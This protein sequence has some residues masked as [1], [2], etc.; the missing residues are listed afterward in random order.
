MTNKE[1]ITDQPTHLATQRQAANGV[2]ASWLAVRSG[3]R[4]LL[5]PLA[6]AGEI[7]SMA[8]IAPVPHTLAWFVG[9]VNLRGGLYGV[10]DLAGFMGD[11]PAHPR[12]AQPT[13]VTFNPDLKLNCAL[14][15]D[16]LA[17][18]R[19]QDSFV[20]REVALAD[21]PVYFGSLLTD[22]EGGQWQ[23]INLHL[24]SQCPEFLRISV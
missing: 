14:V 3:Q 13:V 1:A 18:L 4:N 8:R 12:T 15:V 23:E 7:I 9:V 2:T 20:S 5:F 16:C 22:S 19:R 21:A 17:G 6:Q 11:K 10:V 24:L